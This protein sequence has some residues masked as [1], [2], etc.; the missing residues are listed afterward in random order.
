MQNL[1]LVLDNIR[2]LYNVGAIFRVAAGLGVSKIYLC[3]ITPIPPRKEIH[4]TALGGELLVPWKYESNTQDAIYVLKN[5][6]YLIAALEL[7]ET[8]QSLSSY[9]STSK[10]TQIALIVGHET[11]GID[12]V[13]LTACDIHLKIP[14]HKG[15]HSLNVSTATAIAVWQLKNMV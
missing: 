4:K 9:S 3:G 11:N 6:G 7:T 14:M 2:S 15:I 8:A 12:N 5:D 1:V 10:N 13:V